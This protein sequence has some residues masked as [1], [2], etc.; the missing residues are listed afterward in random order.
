MTDIA[1][2]LAEHGIRLRRYEIGS[3]KTPCP[4]CS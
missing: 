4:T 3:Y 2:Q 1:T